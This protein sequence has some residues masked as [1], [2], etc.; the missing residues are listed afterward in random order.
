VK[1]LIFVIATIFIVLLAAAPV[2]LADDGAPNTQSV[3]IAINGDT[4]LAADKH[5]DG[6]V[7][8]RGTALI[9]GSA[10]SVTVVGG[11]ATIS[12]AAVQTLVVINGQVNLEAGTAISGDIV[13]VGS[14]I[15]TAEGVTVGGS[16]RSLADGLIAAMSF[17]GF[18]AILFWIGIIVAT[19]I[20][21]L[22]VA[23][24]GARQV[25]TS[26]A[27]ISSE[28]IK[29]FVVGLVMMILPVLVF[30]ALAVTIVGL[31]LGLGLLLFVWPAM[32]FFGYMVAAIWIGDWLLTRGGR[33][34][35]E[36]PYLAVTIGLFIS[37]VLGI[38]P[39]ITAIIS[40]FGLGSVTL[41]AWR[42]FT[43]TTSQQRPTFQ[44]L[45][46]PVAH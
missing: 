26:E 31:P 11:T 14:T 7:I 35:A 45:P 40:I 22:A 4:T 23:A 12:G 20:T 41:A 1:R 18:A 9:Q 21:G 30:I 17:L 42:T 29:S 16:S 39:L 44:Q 36:R 5:V 10:N 32:A 25:R 46:T 27:I 38:I 28:P 34:P 43:G 15:N 24:F 37:A 19:W 8:I 33:A 3:V 2:A 13:Q 6:V